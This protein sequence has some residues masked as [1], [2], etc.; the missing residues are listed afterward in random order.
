LAVHAR[1]RQAQERVKNAITALKI[2]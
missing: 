1:I 2:A